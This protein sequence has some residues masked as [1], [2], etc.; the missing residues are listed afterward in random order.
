MPKLRYQAPKKGKIETGFRAFAL[1][2]A[3]ASLKV[4][5]QRS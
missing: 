4:E 1:R 5:W 2:Q 3:N